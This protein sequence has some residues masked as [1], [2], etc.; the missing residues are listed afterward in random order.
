VENGVIMVSPVNF[1][2]DEDIN[3]AACKRISSS[4]H[5]QNRKK[6]DVHCNDI[7]LHRIGAGLG[8]VRLV[9]QGMPEFS[10]LHSLCMVRPD[11]NWVIPSYLLWAFR[12]YETKTQMELGTQSIGVPDLGLDK[13]SSLVFPVPPLSE[14]Q[15]IAD[16]L[17]VHQE[18]IRKEEVYRDKLKL[19]KQGLMHDLLTG[20][21]R[22]KNA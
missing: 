9:T 10:I 12:T 3:F 18:R 20:K 11:E 21:V 22:V 19:Q 2:N 17:N 1:I 14:Q 6:T 15:Q 13:I 16:V 4:A 8:Q 5:L 7:I